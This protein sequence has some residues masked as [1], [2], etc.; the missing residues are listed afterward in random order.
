MTKQLWL[1]TLL[2]SL[3]MTTDA[4][5]QT[6]TWG[7]NFNGQIGDGTS[8]GA[9]NRPSPTTIAGLTD[10]IAVGGGTSHVLVVKADGTVKSGGLNGKGQLGDVTK[11]SGCVFWRKI[12]C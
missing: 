1:C 10:V 8:G 6:K 11:H 3:L 2:A 9:N 7:S 4:F 5:A 12:L